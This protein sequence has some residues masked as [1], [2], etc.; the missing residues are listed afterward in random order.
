MQIRCLSPLRLQDSSEL[1]SGCREGYDLQPKKITATKKEGEDIKKVCNDN[2]LVDLTATCPSGDK[3]VYTLKCMKL[4]PLGNV[5]DEK[6]TCNDTIT[7]NKNGISVIDSCGDN[8][9]LGI[10]K[11]LGKNI[12]QVFSTDVMVNHCNLDG[13]SS[14]IKDEF[15]RN[16]KLLRATSLI[17]INDCRLCL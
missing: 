1:Q 2:T 9:V 12:N 6:L 11:D 15:D 16:I 3:E 4:E 5:Y 7:E 8:I 14:T 10:R 13:N 17:L